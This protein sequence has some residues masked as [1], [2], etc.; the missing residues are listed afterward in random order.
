MDRGGPPLSRPSGPLLQDDELPPHDRLQSTLLPVADLFMVLMLSRPASGTL[1]TTRVT[2]A[3][4]WLGGMV[5]VV[6]SASGLALAIS[7][8]TEAS[9]VRAL[10][11]LLALLV[12]CC[13]AVLCVYGVRQRLA[14]GGRGTAD[15]M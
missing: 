3:T 5:A 1:R 15:K 8:A 6:G 9:F 12:G 10:L 7:G 13:A 14:L 4:V 2:L 11:G